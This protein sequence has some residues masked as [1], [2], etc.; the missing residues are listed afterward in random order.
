[1]PVTASRIPP[2]PAPSSGDPPAVTPGVLERTIARLAR[3][4]CVAAICLVLA[5]VV[6]ID[7]DIVGRALG[8][9]LRGVAETVS[10]AIVAVTFLALPEVARR[11]ALTRETTLPR[12]LAR[13]GP[14]L[15]AW[16][17]ALY[18]A[19]AAIVVA[20]LLAALAPRFVK[21]WE[22]G[23]YRGALGDFTV[24]LWP[25]YLAVVVSCAALAATFGALALRALRRRR[26]P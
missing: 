26:S 19:L 25:L 14:R 10:L 11:G 20:R 5:L 21:A 4:L 6:L 16:V 18:A 22:S 9:P 2:D 3:A 17:E 8:H 24:P 13:R 7:I 1:M 12:A 15:A 23:A